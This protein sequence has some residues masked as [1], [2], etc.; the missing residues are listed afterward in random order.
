MISILKHL[1][2][3]IFVYV[4]YLVN[5][6]TLKVIATYLV[7]HAA[8]L[9]KTFKDDRWNLYSDKVRNWSGWAE[10]LET[11]AVTL[12]YMVYECRH[13]NGGK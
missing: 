13:Q 6:C 4:M 11:D 9:A 5:V 12:F 3:C 8:K 2:L 1:S 7:S 10:V